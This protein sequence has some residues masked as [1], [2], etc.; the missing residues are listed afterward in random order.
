MILT[1]GA[2][3]HL[4]SSFLIRALNRGTPEEA[5]LL[6]WYRERTVLGMSCFALG[7]F[8]CGPP[9]SGNADAAL[10]LVHRYLPLG[11]RE[12]AA[13]AELFNRTGRRSRSFADCLIAATAI[14]DGAALATSNRGDFRRFV[15]A[16][17]VL[18]EQA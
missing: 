1:A 17:L 9:A 3:I 7:E 2:E 6:Q 13:G 11:A 16:G 10:R 5:T 15:D 14:V 4:D 8:L 18:A 12:A